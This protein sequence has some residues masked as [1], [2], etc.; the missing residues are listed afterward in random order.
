VLLLGGNLD[1]LA[2]HDGTAIFPVR[3]GDRREIEFLDVDVATFFHGLQEA[4]I[5]RFRFVLSEQWIAGDAHPLI[6]AD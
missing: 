3:P 1:G 4:K 2:L 5:S 6:V